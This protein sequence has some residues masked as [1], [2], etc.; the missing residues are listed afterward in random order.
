MDAI[1]P[2]GIR[3]LIFQIRGKAVMLDSDL[4]EL[5][6]VQTKV[7]NQAVRRNI[8]RFPDDF[9]FQ[10]TKEEFD[11]L[12]SQTVTSSSGGR[13]YLPFV[14]TEQGV[15]MLSSVLNS[16][17]AIKMNI[18]IIRTF[19]QMR[20]MAITIAD[21]K[22]KIDGMERKYDYHFKVVFDALRK[23]T[24]PEPARKSKHKMGFGPDDKK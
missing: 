21:L 11:N 1:T 15:A 24:A 7:L 14:F 4:A 5:Y 9:M 12:R 16:E 3:N 13:R 18:Q 2:S 6:Q 22:R 17:T 23:L 8:E 20:R 10:L 19:V